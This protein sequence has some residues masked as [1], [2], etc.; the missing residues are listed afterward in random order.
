MDGKSSLYSP[1]FK[2]TRLGLVIHGWLFSS[3][4]VVKFGTLAMPAN[5]PQKVNNAVSRR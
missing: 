2:S 4:H 5:Y 1:G 3:I